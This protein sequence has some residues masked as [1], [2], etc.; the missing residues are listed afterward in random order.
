MLRG[1]CCRPASKTLL[2]SYSLSK[3]S[4]A[5]EPPGRVSVRCSEEPAVSGGVR[6]DRPGQSV[7]ACASHPV[8]RI[9]VQLCYFSSAG[10]RGPWN[11]SSAPNGSGAAEEEPKVGRGREPGGHLS[12]RVVCSRLPFALPAHG[13]RQTGV[14]GADEEKLLSLSPAGGCGPGPLSCRN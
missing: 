1:L 3:A 11:L 9:R 10:R 7:G 12:E 14:N 4:V 13:P 2:S 5:P 8:K 6:D